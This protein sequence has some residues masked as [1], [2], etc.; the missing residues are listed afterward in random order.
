MTDRETIEIQPYEQTRI[1]SRP[2]LMVYHQGDEEAVVNLTVNRTE[3]ELRGP[4]DWFVEVAPT[5]LADV[6]TLSEALAQAQVKWDH[7]D[8]PHEPDL[9][10]LFRAT[11]KVLALFH[12]GPQ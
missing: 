6:G 5:A 2:P 1:G 7:G 8:A 3:V 9:L 11:E 4:T 12:A 10:A